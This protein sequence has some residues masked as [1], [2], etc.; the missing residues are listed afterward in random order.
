MHKYSLIPSVLI[1]LAT[2]LPAWAGETEKQ[3][4]RDYTEIVLNGR[5]FDRLEEFVSA[6]LIQ[7][8]PN[9]PN[10]SAPLQEFWSQFLATMPEARF[11]SARLI[12]E[13]EFVVDHSVF[14]PAEGT[15][16]VAVVDIYRVVD[17]KIVQHWDVST[18]IPESFASGNHPV[19]DDAAR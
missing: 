3:V 9:L 12:S 4:V 6:D 7:H 8:N 19:F 5:E 14:F 16:G 13:G 2:S 10:G 17:G 1:A 11:E 15:A 18:P